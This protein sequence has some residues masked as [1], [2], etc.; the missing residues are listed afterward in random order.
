MVELLLERAADPLLVDGWSQNALEIGALGKASEELLLTISRRVA[1]AKRRPQD[2]PA[3]AAAVQLL[4]AVT[5]VVSSEPELAV[6]K[7]DALE[8]VT[9]SALNTVDTL[10]HW[11]VLHV[12][13]S[14]ALM[15]ENGA[16]VF[17]VMNRC[18]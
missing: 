12:L 14:G 17:I 5:T 3:A 18:R 16:I 9:A 1:R 15:L 13:A 6:D 7:V 4:D 2:K 8:Q 10:D 11:N